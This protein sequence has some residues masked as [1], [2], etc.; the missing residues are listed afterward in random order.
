[1]IEIELLAFPLPLWA[2]VVSFPGPGM[3]DVFFFWINKG[4]GMLI[5]VL[6]VFELVDLF[7]A[8]F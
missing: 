4:C 1:M 6:L 8:V 5:I 2:L 3:W 7:Y